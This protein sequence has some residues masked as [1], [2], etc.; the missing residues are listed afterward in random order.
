LHGHH[1]SLDID[2]I[3]DTMK[4]LHSPSLN[5]PDAG[6]NLKDHRATTADDVAGAVYSPVV[7]ALAEGT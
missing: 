1:G 5:N 4:M 2:Y 6:L 7:D 3:V